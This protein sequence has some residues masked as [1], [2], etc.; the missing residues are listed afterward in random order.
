MSAAEAALFAAQQACHGPGLWLADA[1][2][3]IELLDDRR[4]ATTRALAALLG[5][6][7]G[8]DGELHDAAADDEAADEPA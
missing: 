7:V 5:L 2:R 4:R 6:E 8:D 1:E 3:R